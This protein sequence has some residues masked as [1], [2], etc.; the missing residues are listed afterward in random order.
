MVALGCRNMGRVIEIDDCEAN[1]QSYWKVESSDADM[2]PRV[3][4]LLISPAVQPPYV[5]GQCLDAIISIKSS[6]M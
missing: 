3:I 1:L 2:K 6:P 4:L 5:C